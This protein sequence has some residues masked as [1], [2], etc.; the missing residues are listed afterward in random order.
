MSHN[1]HT[2]SLKRRRTRRLRATAAPAAA[3]TA[4]HPRPPPHAHLAHPAAPPRRRH[5]GRTRAFSPPPYLSPLTSH[6][7]PLPLLPPQATSTSSSAAAPALA[8][9]SLEA[10]FP[11]LHAPLSPA[12]LLYAPF[13]C[14]L[15]A[16]RILLWLACFAL[17]DPALVDA[18]APLELMITRILG[19]R[20]RT[21]PHAHTAACFAHT[22]KTPLSSVQPL[23]SAP[24]ALR[25]Y[26]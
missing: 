19:V 25:R 20:A 24:P 13:G 3:S 26:R 8:P 7:F 15:A 12:L 18:D 2:L 11:R 17:D 6:A 16:A 4:P 1:A 10:L 23:R 5:R 9:P 21:H 14:A 22:R